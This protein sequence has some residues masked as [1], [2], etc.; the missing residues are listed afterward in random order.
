M[1][2]F[3]INIRVSWIHNFKTKIIKMKMKSYESHE[4]IRQDRNIY[5][6]ILFYFCCGRCREAIFGNSLSVR[7]L[8][9]S[10]SEFHVV[11]VL[12]FGV[13]KPA[14]RCFNA[15]SAVGIY[16][17]RAPLTVTAVLTGF[18]A[19]AGTKIAQNCPTL[20]GARKPPRPLNGNLT[21][22]PITM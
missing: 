20:T 7:H 8:F 22:Y 15:M 16:P 21:A 1:P 12:F 5:F 13:S 10:L 17:Y 11:L 14:C 9:L 19:V 2:S 3:K 18:E 6:N 4:S